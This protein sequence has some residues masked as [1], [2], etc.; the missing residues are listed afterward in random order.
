SGGH[1]QLV[2]WRDHFDYTLLGQT[3]DDAVG[4]ALDKVAKILGL[5]YPGGLSIEKVAVH[6]ND[7]A[8]NFPKA[9]MPNKYDYSFSGVK[10]AV[11]RTAQEQ[12]GESFDFPSHKLAERLSEAQKHDIAASFQRIAF[13][14]IVDKAVMAFEEFQPKS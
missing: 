6:G 7:R 4:E 3:R 8:F 10:P 12:I 1:S 2:I 11:L 13:E 9:K 5:P 14:T